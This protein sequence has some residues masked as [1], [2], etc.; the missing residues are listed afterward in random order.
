[1]C[2]SLGVRA[3]VAVG[4]HTEA[5]AEAGKT[6]AVRARDAHAWAEVYT[7]S[8]HWQIVDPTPP[9]RWQQ[10]RH[11]WSMFGDLWQTVRFAWNEKVVGYDE[12]AR[13][14][15]VRWLVGLYRGTK[16]AA[17]DA[18]R[19][20]KNSALNLLVR[21]HI[22]R[23]LSYIFVAVSSVGALVVIVLIERIVRRELQYRRLLRAGKAVPW[24]QLRFFVKLLSL[25]SRRG[26]KFRRDLTPREQM[27][28]AVRSFNL[29]ADVVKELVDLYYSLRW[30]MAP[31]APEKI[32]AAEDHVAMVARMLKK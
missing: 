7:P 4:F 20:L 12:T 15:V 17:G 11:W 32:R 9:G 6:I 22:D 13:Q 10:H 5:P 18:L 25:L 30:G 29:P 8:T 23:A 27:A 19:T 1:M 21:G 3:R 2:R 26:M 28:A 14:H 24:P 16:A 31:A